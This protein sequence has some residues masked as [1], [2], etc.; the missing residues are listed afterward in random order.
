E[1]LLAWLSPL[2]PQ[3]R[4]QDIK[5]SRLE[6]TGKWILQSDQFQE[7]IKGQSKSESNQVLGCYG[8]PGVGKTV[9]ASIVI[10]YISANLIRQRTSDVYLYCD[11]RDRREQNLVHI[12]GSFVKQLVLQFISSGTRLPQS[13]HDH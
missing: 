7:W 12:I 4:H 9:I 2:E 8:E 10:D 6:N 5:N 13:I 3:K 1:K 11:Y